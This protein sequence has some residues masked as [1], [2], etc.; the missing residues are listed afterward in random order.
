MNILMALW[1]REEQNAYGLARKKGAKGP[2]T[3]KQCEEIKATSLTIK[4][5]VCEKYL[6]YC[7]CLHLSLVM[8]WRKVVL[9]YDLGRY[10]T[11]NLKI[12]TSMRKSIAAGQMDFKFEDK[13]ATA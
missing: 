11:S 4:R 9:S 6:T 1:E 5:A 7:K 10:A 3:K 8:H 13:R 2:F 12:R